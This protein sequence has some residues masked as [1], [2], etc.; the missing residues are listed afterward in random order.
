MQTR[1]LP[2]LYTEFP[3]LTRRWQTASAVSLIEGLHSR[4]AAHVPDA[5]ELHLKLTTLNFENC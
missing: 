1:S 5:P 2:T 4:A 3:I